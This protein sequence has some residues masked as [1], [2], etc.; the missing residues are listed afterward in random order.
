M[1]KTA[2]LDAAAELAG[3]FQL[4]RVAGVPP[5]QTIGFAALGPLLAPLTGHLA[6]LPA[7]QQR[8]VLACL[9]RDGAD[10]SRAGDLL[11]LGA[12]VLTLFAEGS[13]ARPLLL[14]VDDLHWI[15]EESKRVVGFVARRLGGEQVVMLLAGRE[16][17]DV[18]P[19]LGVR[20]AVDGLD[21]HDAAQLLVRRRPELR[22]DVT[23]QLVSRCRGNA[24]ALV[25]SAASIDAERAQGRAPLDEAGLV[26][27]RVREGYRHRLAA[28]SE[29][30]RTALLVAA[31]E[32]RGEPSVLAD[33]VAAF[34][35]R[36]TDLGSG[37]GR[38]ADPARPRPVPLPASDA[39]RLRQ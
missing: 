25:E 19:G 2:L 10:R 33:A 31:C 11:A 15:D 3:D 28:L 5:E 20:I 27:S 21:D 17:G 32:G 23:D 1:G 12:G 22:A 30:T 26:P 18:P 8:A 37:R 13:R 16:E 34:G 24:L 29:Q 9:A 35:V 14:L 36:W 6:A 38:G 39:R 4:A 7:R